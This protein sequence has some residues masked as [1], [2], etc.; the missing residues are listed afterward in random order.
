MIGN[1]GDRSDCVILS[2]RRVTRLAGGG[3]GGGGGGKW[4]SHA[5]ALGRHRREKNRNLEKENE[6]RVFDSREIRK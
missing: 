4:R 2:E 1:E 3:G 6:E 5:W